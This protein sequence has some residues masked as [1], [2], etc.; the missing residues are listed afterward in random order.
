MALTIELVVMGSLHVAM[1]KKRA[2]QSISSEIGY[3]VRFLVVLLGHL[4]L[5]LSL[6]RW[7]LIHCCFV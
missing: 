2:L 4:V 6:I 1:E 7:M 3:D 5:L